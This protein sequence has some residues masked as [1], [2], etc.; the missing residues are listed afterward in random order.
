[1]LARLVGGGVEELPKRDQPVF[2]GAFR[3]SQ[4]VG[5][6]ERIE[7]RGVLSH[8][9]GERSLGQLSR[10]DALDERVLQRG[11]RQDSVPL[12]QRLGQRGHQPS[13]RLGAASTTDGVDDPNHS[14]RPTPQPTRD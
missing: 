7:E 5:A 10:C 13:L 2:V 9:V 6:A 14:Q 3:Q 11:L 12:P 8:V 1:M 4:G